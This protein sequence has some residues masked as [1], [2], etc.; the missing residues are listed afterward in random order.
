MYISYLPMLLLIVI[1][2]VL[3]LL[4]TILINILLTF[5]NYVK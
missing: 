3:L 4:M 5:K 2:K 1:D